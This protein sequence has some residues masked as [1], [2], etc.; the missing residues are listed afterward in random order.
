[1]KQQIISLLER[2][3][4]SGR[5]IGDV[6]AE[7]Q[8]MRPV[9]LTCD[10]HGAVGNILDTVPCPD[11]SQH[12][13]TK[14]EWIT[15][16]DIRD[17]PDCVLTPSGIALKQSQIRAQDGRTQVDNDLVSSLLQM[18]SVAP[19]SECEILQAAAAALASAPVA[20]EAQPTEIQSPRPSGVLSMDG[21]SLHIKSDGSGQIIVAEDDFTLEDDRDEGPDGPQ[22]SIHW[23]ARLPA[24]EVAVLRDFLTGHARPSDDALWDQTLIERDEY[25]DMADKLAHAIADHLLVEIGEHSSSN[26]P[27]MRALEAIESAAPQASPAADGRDAKDAERLDFLADQDAQIQSLTLDNGT[28]YRI[29]WPDPDEAQSEWFGSPRE[30]IDA[31]IAAQQGEGGGA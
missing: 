12:A 18:A 15:T 28:K 5:T 13:E 14:L 7:V 3:K 23:V 29:G 26:C 20:G 22:G 8:G 30:A 27:W 24:S 21:A 6:L 17:V 31:A 19:A 16:P 2:A 9:C 10:D 1:M 11:C 25:H 4:E